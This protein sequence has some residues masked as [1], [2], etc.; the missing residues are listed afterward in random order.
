M[1]E[2]RPISRQAYCSD[3]HWRATVEVVDGSN[4]RQVD[5]EVD[6]DLNDGTSTPRI[7]TADGLWVNVNQAFVSAFRALPAVTNNSEEQARICGGNLPAPVYPL[8]LTGSVETTGIVSAVGGHTYPSWSGGFLGASSLFPNASLTTEWRPVNGVTGTLEVGAGPTYYATQPVRSPYGGTPNTVPVDFPQAYI[9]FNAGAFCGGIGRR[10]ERLGPTVDAVRADLRSFP[11]VSIPFTISPYGQ[12]AVDLGACNDT[13]NWF[14]WTST[15]A[16][17]HWSPPVGPYFGSD[18]SLNLGFFSLAAH[19]QAGKR[20][21]DHPENWTQMGDLSLIFGASDDPAQF[22]L[23]GLFGAEQQ[24]STHG[25]WTPWGSVYGFLPIHP[26]DSYLGGFFRAGYNFLP[27]IRSGLPYPVDVGQFSA[28]LAVYPFRTNVLR[29]T[30]GADVLT[31]FGASQPFNG[32]DTLPRFM[33]QV[34]LADSANVGT[35][36]I[37]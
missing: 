31:T 9:Q 13:V 19:Y 3:D 30:A 27:P 8:R 14:V 36:R 15:G 16:D 20:Q 25:A 21:A 1:T 32:S 35:P 5:V 12:T 29:I 37:P 18:L 23:Y 33:L 4:T 6:L 28:G 11:L 24:T 34:T 10:Y 22:I 2:Y 26:K 17:G 7:Q